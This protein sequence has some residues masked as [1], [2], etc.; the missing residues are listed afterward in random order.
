MRLL[1]LNSIWVFA[2]LPLV[3]SAETDIAD[4][5]SAAVRFSLGLAE[6]TQGHTVEFGYRL[7]D[8]FAVRGLYGQGNFGFDNN[9]D[10]NT[11]SGDV[12][13]G[14]LGLM[15]DYYIGKGRYRVSAG[16][17]QLEHGLSASTIGT[18]TIGGTT[19]PS[20]LDVDGSFKNDIAPVVSLGFQKPLFGSNVYFTGDLGAMFTGGAQVS[21][22]DPNGII[23][24][25]AIDE[26]VSDLESSLD[27]VKV[28][29]FLKI[30]VGF[31]F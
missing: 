10:D 16:V 3:A 8:K 7:N 26:E 28:A 30:G 5:A 20:T 12:D 25:T 24:Q 17:L 27:K 18:T 31:N 11:Y 14:G 23:P 1:P 19:Y 15:F 13:L 29:P 22:T 9:I 4:E 2:T 6:S 21:A